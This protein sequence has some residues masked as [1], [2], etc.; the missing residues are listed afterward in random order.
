MRRAD[1]VAV[2]EGWNAGNG[3]KAGVVEHRMRGRV[4]PVG[5]ALAAVL[6]AGAL[7]GCS[8]DEPEAAPKS[9]STVLVPGRP[10]EPNK[11]A[12][13]GPASAAPPTAAE[14]RFVEMMIP[15][16]R[17]A[18]EM[19]GLAPGQAADAK[20]KSLAHRIGA[21]QQSEMAAMES[22]LKKNG[23][24]GASPGGGHGGGHASPSA[25]ATSHAGMPGMATP[26]QMGRLRAARGAD[27]DRLFLTLM[28]THHQGALTMT[29]DALDKGTN[30]IV[31]ELARDVQSSQ[32][33]EIDRLRT[34]LPKD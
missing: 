1:T 15:H 28:I 7:S 6:A 33:A 23:R 12:V 27:F 32:Q 5:M 21:G 24:P 3:G 4:V 18:V 26:E 31:Q 14:I 25:A 20:V 17:Q 13:R 11:T 22:W 16:H 30:V 29:K 34:L 2:T 10:G 8:G 19:A 9:E